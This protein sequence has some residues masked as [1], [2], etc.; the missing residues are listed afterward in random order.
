MKY[1]YLILVI[2]LLKFPAKQA[3]NSHTFA[4]QF[5][6]THAY[7]YVCVISNAPNNAGVEIKLVLS[8]IK[9]IVCYYRKIHTKILH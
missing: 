3:K 4:K 5:I 7:M 2:F 1:F 6:Y 9:N 8:I